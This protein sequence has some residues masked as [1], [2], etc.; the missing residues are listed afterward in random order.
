[1]G[2]RTVHL[3]IRVAV[4]AALLLALAAPGSALAAG[5]PTAT[6]G[7]A[8]S[9]TQSTVT[10]TGRVTPNGAATTYFFQYGPTSLYGA[11]TAVATAAKKMTVAVPVGGLAPFTTYH[12]R[13]VAQNG[14]GL[15]KGKDRTFKTKRQPLGVSLIAT[16]NP[17]PFGKPT[18]LQGILS[19]TGNAGRT[20]VLQVNPFPYT[21]GFVNAANA[22]VTNAQG[23]FSFPLL[24][25]PVN[26]QFRVLMT[27]RPGVVSP[28][29]VAY[30]KVRVTAHRQVSHTH[31]GKI[32]RF[33][34]SVT[35]ANDGARF[36]VQRFSK[37]HW[38][39]VTG[40]VTHH[41]S[42]TSSAYSKRVRIRHSGSYRV[43]VEVATGQFAS[44]AGYTMH[45][46]R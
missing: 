18:T 45:V 23:V 42:A 37:G 19:G 2:G 24:S 21:Q 43:F 1:M 33:Y 28:V 6:T 4:G 36:A 35:P 15:S 46:R 27:N 8:A 29:I 13:L 38:R 30:S 7:A 44:S 31:R 25:L 14:H 16:P 10:L 34:G 22:Q 41:H 5:K 17:V 20:V 3:R 26:A 40:G 39:T 11:S 12:Y 32:I 9:I